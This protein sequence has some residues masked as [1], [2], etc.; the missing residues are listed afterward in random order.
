VV[1]AAKLIAYLRTALAYDAPTRSVEVNEW[2]KRA[3]RPFSDSG[4]PPA[5]LAAEWPRAYAVAPSKPQ[6]GENSSVG[7]SLPQAGK[8]SEPPKTHHS[9]GYGSITRITGSAD[10]EKA[11]GFIRENW[12]TSTTQPRA[13]AR[14]AVAAAHR[15]ERAME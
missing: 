11:I 12:P 1:P 9:R 8:I 6:A 2:Q 7:A 13:S 14:A 10:V 3:P 4:L 5:C 15:V